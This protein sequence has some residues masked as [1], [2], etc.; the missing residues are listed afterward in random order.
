MGQIRWLV[1]D[2]L[3]SVGMACQRG[4]AGYSMRKKDG[5]RRKAGRFKAKARKALREKEP[6]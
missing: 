2:R 1:L 4:A 3:T 5:T 6:W